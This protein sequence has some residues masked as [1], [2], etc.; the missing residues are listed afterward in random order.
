[1]TDAGD[2]MIRP[3]SSGWTEPGR[4]MNQA[5]R[6]IRAAHSRNSAAGNTGKP[7]TEASWSMTCEVSTRLP[8]TRPAS[9]ALAAQKD[10]HQTLRVNALEHRG[11]L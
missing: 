11:L 7:A 10:S 8:S 6:A 2:S 9:A 4:S 5:R 1:M 3:Y